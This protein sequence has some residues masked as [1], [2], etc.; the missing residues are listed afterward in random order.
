MAVSTIDPKDV[1]ISIGGVPVSGFTN[2]TFLE[3]VADQQQFTKVTG[4]DG[5]VTRVKSNDYGATMTL[6]L[7]QSS[8]SND[9][10]SAIFNADRAING[11]VVPILIK[12]LSGTTVIFSATGWIQ[13]FPDITYSN[14]FTERA[15]VFDLANVDFFLGGNG[16]VQP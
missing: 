5:Y 1:V 9:V 14:E 7:A 15:W 11:G 13:Q 16:V 10:L 2:G 3:I 8:P 4:A 12:D 6:T